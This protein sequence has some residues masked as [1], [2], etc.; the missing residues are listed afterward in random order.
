MKNFNSSAQDDWR[1][2]RLLPRT[3]RPRILAREWVVF[4]ES[5][6]RRMKRKTWAGVALCILLGALP[7]AAQDAPP[8]AGV[9]K[10]GDLRVI[11]SRLVGRSAQDSLVPVDVIQAE[12][13]QTYG[14][15]DMDAL[16]AASVPSYNV[17][18]RAG[19]AAALVRPAN[20][21]GLPPDSTLVLVNGK[22]RHRAAVITFLGNGNSDGAQGADISVI[23]AIALKRLEVLRDGSSSQYGSDAIA[24]ALNFVLRDDDEGARL[25]ARW[26]QNYHGDGDKVSVAGNVGLPLTERGFANLSF[27]FMHGDETSRSVQRSDAL[28][29]IA[30]GNAHVRRPAQFFGTPAVQYNYKFFGN[31][32]LDLTDRH[33]LYAFG[34]YAERKAQGHFFFRNPNTRGGVFRG[35]P[36][37]DGT[38]TVRVADLSDDLTG[39]PAVPAN[40]AADYTNVQLP[41]HCFLFNERFPGGFAPRFGGTMQDWSI[42]FGLRGDLF[43][44]GSPLLDGWHYDLSAGFGHNSID[45]FMHN[46]INPQLAHL[47]TGI[48]TSYKPGSYTEFD[49]VFNVDIARPFDVGLFHSALNL[50]FGLEYREEEFTANAGEPNSW[51][52]EESLARQGFG[53]GSNGFPGL[54]PKYAG[55]FDRGSYAGYLDL[56]AD[57]LENLTLGL[58][59][60]YEDYEEVGDTLNGKASARWT[61]PIPPLSEEGWGRLAVR[62]S[63]GSGFRAPTVGQANV[64][65]VTTSLINGM[66]AD[67]ATL[68]PTDPIAQQKGGRPLAPEKSVNYSVGAVFSLGKLDVTLDYY[69]IKMQ[70]RIGLTKTLPLTGADI[71]ALLARGVADASSFTG[72][73]YFTND[74]DT[75]TQGVDLVATYP[76]ET[77]AGSTRFTFVGNWNHTTVDSRN[78]AIIDDG[79]VRQ[80]EDN[81]PEFRFSLTSD[82]SYGPWRLLTRL[83]FYDGFYAAYLRDLPIEAGER[84]LVDAELSYTLT[85]LPFM[86]VATLAFGAENLFDRYPARNPYARLAGAKYPASSPYGFNGGFYYL[87]ASFEF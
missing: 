24:G 70:D 30:A 57:V 74:F 40:P 5:A 87:R 53:V 34:N 49:K 42:A 44:T 51:T 60:R 36:L 58:A 19:D 13:L 62:G 12:D 16:L 64:R 59:G 50:A 79:R 32:G 47:R 78:P 63:V 25:E 75:T 72:V 83:H 26:G 28:G 45:F 81:L 23:P 82:H 68:S 9:A 86:G 27:E 61:P 84:W 11:G 14:I 15:R 77:V 7:V 38:P 41:E 21:R 1:P 31:L 73:R 66:L 85:N 52:I 80:L 22:R 33:S 71:A 10:L 29:L 43:D 8:Q 6:A 65:N 55:T 35:D 54:N 67:E 69:R 18:Q 39:C 3:R 48:P 2:G 37:T 4:L 20:M 17:N 56:E 76:L 46:T